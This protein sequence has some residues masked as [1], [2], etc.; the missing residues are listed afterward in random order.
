MNVNSEGEEVDKWVD[1]DVV[2]VHL[3]RS[4]VYDKAW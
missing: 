4:Y 3:V 2:C 1:W